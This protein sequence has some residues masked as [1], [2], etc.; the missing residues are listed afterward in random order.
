MR[1]RF[2]WDPQKAAGNLCKHR[3]S[4]EVAVRVFLDPL[5]MTEVDQII[6]GEVRWKTLGFV[7]SLVSLVVIH[8]VK[9]TFE[10][11]EWIRIISARRATRAE[12]RCYEEENG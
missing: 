11:E 8:T 6:E 2:E 5:R 9:E 10:G 12:R 1:I 7:D 3:I 4:F